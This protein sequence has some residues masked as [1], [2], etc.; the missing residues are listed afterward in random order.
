MSY[1]TIIFV[2]IEY[3]KTLAENS[4]VHQSLLKGFGRLEGGNGGMDLEKEFLLDMFFLC[5]SADCTPL[6]ENIY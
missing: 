3:T 1:F 4:I 6:Q 2:K 5:V